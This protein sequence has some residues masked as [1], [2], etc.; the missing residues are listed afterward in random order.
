MSFKPVLAGFTG[1]KA[2]FDVEVYPNY[3]LLT[4]HDLDTEAT[5]RFR[6]DP[7]N[8]T[9]D[10]KAAEAYYRSLSVAVSYNGH[11]YDDHILDVVF[12]GVDCF[13]VWEY[14]DQIIRS[15]GRR[16]SPFID[17]HG[18][19]KAGFPLSLD[20]AALLTAKIGESKDGKPRFGFPGLKS[21]GNRF[22]Y[23]HLQTL[24]I[25]P[26][27]T[28]CDEQ[29]RTIDAYN[30]HDIAVT[31]LVLEHLDAAIEMRRALGLQYGVNLI[32]RADAK[33][34]EMMVKT[35][36]TAA[37][38]EKILAQWAGA[39]EPEPFVLRPPRK[40][41]WVCGGTDILS[42]RHSFTDPNLVALLNKVKGWTMHWRRWVDAN[43]SVQMDKPSFNAKV[44]L[45]DKTYSFGLGGLHS[46]DDP[47]VIEADETHAITDIDVSSYYPGLVV[48]ERIAPGHL[49]ADIFCGVFAGLMATRLEAKA[50]KQKEIAQGM[51]V[52]INSGGY[53]KLSDRYSPFRDPPKGAAI[54]I[55]GQ[56]ILLRLIEGLLGIEGV[57]ILSAN[58]D[59]VLIHH[60]REAVEQIHRVMEQ[61][62]DIYR[63]NKFDVIEVIRLC[64]ASV[65]EY[66][67]SYRDPD[68][69]EM[70]IKGR[71]AAFNDGT[72][73]ENL[74]K[75][76]DKRI[77]K[78]ALI[79]YLLFDKPIAE[80]VKRCR[81]LI[82]F[83][84][85]E[86]LHDAWDHIEDA[87]G[88]H[89]PQT[90]NRWYESTGG[91]MLHKVALDGR[92]QRYPKMQ[93]V[94]VVNDLP[95]EFPGDVNYDYYIG[96]AQRA[97]N[98]ILHP[99]QKMASRRK[100][101]DK[102]NDEEREEWED[103]QNETEIDVGW[104]TSLDLNYYR[105]LY[106]GRVAIN[107]YDSMRASLKA[108]WKSELRM[109]KA[110]LIWCF[111]SFNTADG[112]FDRDQ[113]RKSILSYID[114][115]VENI[116]PMEKEV[117]PEDDAPISVTVM[118]LDDEPGG[119][120]TRHALRKIVSG[121]PGKVY[122]WAINKISPLASERF[123]EL[124]EHAEAAGVKI[125]FL[126][127]HCEAKGR[128]TMKMRIDA[129][130]RE[131]NDHP[132]KDEIIFVTIITHKTLI[133]HYLANV[134]GILLIDEPVQVWEQRHFEFPASFRTMRQLIVPVDVAADYDGDLN[135]IID[136]DTQ[137]VRFVLTEEGRQ[138]VN[139]EV[140]KRDTIRS[141]YRWI[142]EQADKSSGRVYALAEQWN[143]I[144][145][146]EQGGLDVLA[147][148]HPEAHR[149]LR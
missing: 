119:G 97:A 84:G 56:L 67:M 14:G 130:M 35:A 77:I 131:I 13:D 134:S 22:G 48:E 6:I 85:Y 63:L 89:L 143:S 38:N 117:F 59:G 24:P 57:R 144:D 65:N 116:V 86:T 29:K 1:R 71:G 120:K 111:E 9:D 49:D 141:S 58:T 142:I 133:D 26:G 23:K 81:D 148:L 66:V 11:G 60:P 17:G 98:D 135:S 3:I 149:A 95:D 32:S 145:D 137:A 44:K 114:W 41:D 127:I 82:M 42:D 128:G 31:R 64:R 19:P 121:G 101:A 88:N 112:Y 147:L 20:L 69:G 28:L 118:V 47:L 96:E 115:V 103:R 78:Q 5:T 107:A 79:D 129:R 40:T 27:T 25:R 18:N 105:D 125:D 61:V 90:T 113:K 4:F 16:R 30:I 122:W 8:D 53:G 12:K 34:A 80:T 91:T 2:L 62:R 33:L 93:R 139:D 55:N 43:G 37:M 126:P 52:A 106:T 50:K 100:K 7:D 46:E 36:Y 110:D 123:N 21:L 94:V 87:D 72:K 83:V 10:R 146:T 136:T 104:L 109:S 51:K 76:T 138:E 92:R 99:K 124:Q 75:K 102:L 39:E 74:N 68:T 15:T 108:L 45:R 140:L 70:A 73:T 132:S 54:T